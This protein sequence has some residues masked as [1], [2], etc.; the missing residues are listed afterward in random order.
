MPLLA[1]FAVTAVGTGLEMAANSEDQNA[2]NSAEQST[3][4]QLAEDQKKNDAIMQQQEAGQGA[5]V[6][7]KDIASGAAQRNALA[8]VLKQASMPATD[9]PISSTGADSTTQGATARAASRGN[10][11]SNVVNNAQNQEGGYGDWATALDVGNKN[12]N[13]QLGVV[14]TEAQG[15]ANLL[16]LEV[17][18]AS[19]K[20][21]ALSGW[22]QIVSALGQVASLGAAT[23]AFGGAPAEVD[24]NGVPL[25]QDAA[26]ASEAG[27]APA[28]YL[29][30]T[31]GGFFY[32]PNYL[33]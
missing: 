9:V 19:H 8:N 20:G 22:G 6:A 2:I 33:K 32:S 27:V 29:P 7:Q 5:S 30:S 24:A 18:V 16:P 31:P 4:A 21:D 13:S 17:Q 3:N 25:A 28:S 11:W 26:V 15:T 14:N 10:A 23:G 1:A 12:T